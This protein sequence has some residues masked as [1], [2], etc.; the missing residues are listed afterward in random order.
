MLRKIPIQLQDKL[1]IVSVFLIVMKVFNQL[2]GDKNWGHPVFT[3]E[4]L[5]IN[6]I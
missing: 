6:G 3:E 4:R 2:P 1:I 5:K